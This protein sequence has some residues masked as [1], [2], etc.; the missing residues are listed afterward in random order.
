MCLEDQSYL[1]ENVLLNTDNRKAKEVVSKGRF[2][3]LLG[4]QDRG[5]RKPVNVNPG[6][7]IN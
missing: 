2:L 1:H 7:N 5:V 6:L 3:C 4:D